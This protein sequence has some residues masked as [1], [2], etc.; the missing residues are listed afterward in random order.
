MGEAPVTQGILILLGGVGLFLLGMK[1]MTEA[2]REAAGDRL[3]NLLARFTTTPLRGTLTGTAATAVVQS[4][5]A[6]SLM[7]V[8][9][10]GAGMLGFP[11][12]LGVLYGANIGTTVT[13]WIVTVLG[14]KLQLGQIALPGI[15]LASLLALFGQGSWA[16]AG[17]GLAGFCLLFIGLDMMQ[18]G[19]AGTGNLLTPDRLPG[20]GWGGRLAQVGI[21]L[22]IVTVT[23]SSSAA[24][25]MALV[26]LASGS[27]ALAQAAAMVIG[28]NLGTT[29][30][31][32][33][34]SLGGSRGMQRTAVANLLFNLVTATLAFPL[35]GV[36]VPILD[37]LGAGDPQTALMIFHT[38]F[39]LAG[40]LLFLPVTTP[41]ARAVER[42][43]PDKVPEAG[44]AQELDPALRSEPAVALDAAQQAVKVLSGEV[45]AALSAALG[46]R[47]DLRALSAL[48]ERVGPGI[49]SLSEFLDR[50]SIPE[51]QAKLRARA[52]GLLHQV[53]HLARLLRRAEKRSVLDTIEGESR[54]RRPARVLCETLARSV[55]GRE[56][57]A[58]TARRLA[59]LSSLTERR[60]ERHRRET[61]A[62]E[63]EGRLGI[64]EIYRRTDA[65]RWLARVTAH[66]ERILWH[67]LPAVP[68]DQRLAPSAATIASPISEVETGVPPAGPIRSAVRSPSASTA[69]TAFSSRSASA[70]SSKE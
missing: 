65:V 54:L 28:M 66:A 4:S 33:L 13:G 44:P 40:T 43:L 8:G 5:T 25:A 16:R 62:P 46:P 49:V 29:L 50:L 53:D 6:V 60:A 23:Q 3:R 69:S 24:V 15:F 42:I 63:T 1:T 70:P 18:A 30:T 48:P 7:T 26:L 9:F 59:R 37:R 35:V 36:V 68:G 11:Q 52:T 27:I 47:K 67:R 19:L 45:F 34:A 14:F 58:E 32:V 51:D 39:N 17:R 22:V 10:V 41:F 2:L 12:A 57:D 31:A 56:A 20:D 38:G 61:L 64:A 55:E 21:G